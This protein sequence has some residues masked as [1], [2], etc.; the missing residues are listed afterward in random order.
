M[1]QNK[2]YYLK[3]HLQLSLPVVL[4]HAG[5][6]ITALADTVMVGH[7]GKESLGAVTFAHSIFV[8][9]FL[10]GVGLASGLTPVSG[11]ANGENN[12]RKLSLI[13]KNSALFR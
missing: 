10:F 9:P 6:M 4:G 11:K 13:F 3:R 12:K 2:M 8:V 5:H 1:I 7:L